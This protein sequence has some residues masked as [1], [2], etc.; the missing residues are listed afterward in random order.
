MA[1]RVELH[2][3]RGARGLAPENT[4]EGFRTALT[5]GVD[6][7]ELDVAI[8]ADGVPVASHDPALNPDI[9]RTEDGAWVEPPTRLIREMK[10]AE[11]QTYDVGRLR[12]GTR[13]AAIYPDQRPSD[14]ARI[15]SLAEVFALDPR[16]R[17]NIELKL[18]PGDPARTVPP[19]EMADL[20]VAAADAAGVIARINVMSFDWRPLRHLRRTRPDVSLAFLTED[21]TIRDAALWWDGVTPAEHGGSVARTVAAEGGPTWSPH[22]VDLSESAVAEAH[23]LGL[24]VVPWTVNQPADMDRLIAWGVDGL[25]TDR[26]DLGRAALLRAGLPVP[27]PVD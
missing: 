7:L 2:G 8:T 19:A 4:L 17:F 9:T 1:R 27:P 15:P 10:L 21:A 23:E 12:P 25:I 26:P 24:R 18:F 20:V 22:H 13:Y 14:G 16:A 11:V 6:A 5:I 3:H